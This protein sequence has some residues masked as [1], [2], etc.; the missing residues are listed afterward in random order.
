MRIAVATASAF[1]DEHTFSR[2]DEIMKQ[3]AGFIILDRSAHRNADLQMFSHAPVAITTLTMPAAFSP[4]IMV[5]AKFQKRVFVRIR[6]EINIAAFAAITAA[7]PA[8]RDK[9][10]PPERNA[11]VTAVAGFDCDFG[12]VDEHG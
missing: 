1:C 7:G 9:L 8:S 4:E 6:D 3:L 11:S 2:L 5:K 12:F 10:L